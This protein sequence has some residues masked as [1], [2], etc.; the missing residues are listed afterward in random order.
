MG[1]MSDDEA[2]PKD[3]YDGPSLRDTALST[4]LNYKEMLILALVMQPGQHFTLYGH[5]QSPQV[6]VSISRSEFS[7]F[8]RI[9]D[10]TGPA[11]TKLTKEQL[12]ALLL[13][14]IMLTV[15][16]CDPRFQGYVRPKT[17]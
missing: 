8:R 5:W 12:T 1:K 10:L 11:L 16:A 17:H 15:D 14:R 9:L 13:E 3:P 6:I 2:D 4:V 7:Y